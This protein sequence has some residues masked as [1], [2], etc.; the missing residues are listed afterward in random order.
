[1]KWFLI[2][3]ALLPVALGFQKEKPRPAPPSKKPAP[4]TRQAKES[5][6]NNATPAAAWQSLIVAM[7]N[8]EE[9][10]I[11]ALTTPAGMKSLRETA[12]PS[13]LMERLQD[14]TLYLTQVAIRWQKQT[15]N[16]IEARIGPT[17]K[18]SFLSFKKTPQGWKLDCLIPGD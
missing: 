14:W 6:L 4:T 18:E 10:K 11:L 1:M 13:E 5:N 12:A 8:K 3:P 16:K 7:Q 2:L 15:G 9:K 17:N